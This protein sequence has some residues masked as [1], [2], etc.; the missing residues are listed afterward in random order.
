MSCIVT[1]AT[2]L[3]PVEGGWHAVCSECGSELLA[4]LDQKLRGLKLLHHDDGSH[5][6][7][8]TAPKGRSA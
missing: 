7:T 6:V 1:K 5:T 2:P 8:F 3:K 4:S